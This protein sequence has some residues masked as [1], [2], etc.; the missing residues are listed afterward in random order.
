MQGIACGYNQAITLMVTQRMRVNN[1]KFLSQAV[2]S[3]SVD[4][5]ERTP[6][7]MGKAIESSVSVM[8]WFLN[9]GEQ[10]RW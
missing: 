8:V 1:Q 9:N 2:A 4:S 5:T 10:E 6:K 7:M 3:Y